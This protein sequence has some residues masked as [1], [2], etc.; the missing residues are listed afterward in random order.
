[1]NTNKV[2]KEALLGCDRAEVAKYTGMTLGSLNNQ[3]SGEKPYCPKGQTPNM[4]DRVYRLIDITYTTTGNMVIMEKLAEEFGFML[5]QNPAIRAD[6]SPAIEQIAKILHEFSGMIEEIGD[7]NAD[8]RIEPFEAEKIRLK[9]EVLKRVIESFVTACET[10]LY[11]K[12]ED[13]HV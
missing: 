12:T 4:L 9:W 5:I 11:N 3:V 13:S 7:A 1:M 2:L 8:G 10:N 6:Q